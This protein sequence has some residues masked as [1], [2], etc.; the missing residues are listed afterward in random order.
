M[1]PSAPARRSRR[2]PTP[3]RALPLL[4]ALLAV[5]LAG[6]PAGAQPLPA[7][8]PPAALDTVRTNLWLAQ[9]LMGEVVATTAAA[10]PPPPAAVAL[11][12]RDVGPD[13][14][15]FTVV[16]GHWLR[17]RGYTVHVREP[18]AAG[19]SAA[20]AAGQ[21][22]GGEQGQAQE[23]GQS[24]GG[25]LSGAAQAAAGQGG[26]AGTPEAAAGE[27]GEA[28]PAEAAP[29]FDRGDATA[30][31]DYELRY[32][33]E[34]VDLTYPEVGRLLGLWQR[35]VERRL[36]VAA[37]M[38][39]V[40][41]RSGRV[42]L[43]DRIVRSYGDRIGGDAFAAVRSPAYDFTDASLQESGWRRRLEEIVV[44][45]TLAGL[46]AVYFANTGN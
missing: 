11:E 42:L 13:I 45:G 28:P 40:E 24:G 2:P 25:G 29:A 15:L 35:W 10:L 39:V 44:V 34:G 32:R 17:R 38:T 18:A 43:S 16:A 3:A 8:G 26:D 27:G 30:P 41:S 19:R 5:G 31:V 12:P 46:V 36:E 1:M 22:T 9:A 23:G 4:L 14:D 21:S 6:A 20:Q 7:F 37:L 33:L